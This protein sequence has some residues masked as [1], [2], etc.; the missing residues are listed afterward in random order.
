MD[1]YLHVCPAVTLFTLAYLLRAALSLGVAY[2]W[3]LSKP[4]ATQP[5]EL[6]GDFYSHRKLK[7]EFLMLA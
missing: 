4:L 5:A 3:R 1:T 6:L 7:M 2:L